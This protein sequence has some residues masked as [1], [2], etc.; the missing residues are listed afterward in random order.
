MSQPSF[1]DWGY[2]II[3][4]LGWGGAFF[5]NAIL[6][7]EIGPLSISLVRVGFGALACWAVVALFGPRQMIPLAQILP[8][9]IFGL[10][11][12]GIPLALYPLAQT[13]LASGVTGIV[14]AMTPIMVVIVSHF[15]PGGERATWLRSFGVIAG[16]AGIVLLAL[17]EFS[18]GEDS[19]LWAMLIALGAPLSYALAMNYV[20]VI[21][22]LDRTLMTAAAMTAASLI[23]APLVISV[24]GVPHLTSPAGWAAA[25]FIGIVLTGLSF[26]LMFSMLPRIGPTNASTVTFVAPVSAVGLG[27]LV[28]G[29][30]I[31]PLHLVGM[32]C[33]MLGLLLIDGRLPRQLL[34]K[35]NQKVE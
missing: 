9:T 14:N 29:E 22:G 20:R 13:S 33:I 5:L 35:L 28:L 12:F 6:L 24:E 25:L 8:L 18:A 21:T 3:L 1:R 10:L 7:R 23:L 31:L 19:E 11:H 2:I 16:F 26:A 4:G 15:W 17:P 32:G 34:A 30:Q 27:A